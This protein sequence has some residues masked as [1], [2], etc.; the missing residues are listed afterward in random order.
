MTLPRTWKIA[1]SL[2]AI[3]IAGAVTGGVLTAIVAKKMVERSK[4]PEGWQNAMYR[5][6][7]NRLKLTPE[8]EEKLRPVFK[9]AAEELKTV[10]QRTFFE[11]GMVVRKMNESVAAELTPGQQDELKKMTEEIRT[12]FLQDR[13]TNAPPIP[14]D[15]R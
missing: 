13:R 8:Q 15:Q 12:K 5:H 9:I 6:Y 7:K 10:R 11:S 3:F 14:L 4:T 1:L 2:T